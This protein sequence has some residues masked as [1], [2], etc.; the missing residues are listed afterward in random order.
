MMEFMLNSIPCWPIIDNDVM[1]LFH[2]VYV[3]HLDINMSTT[4]RLL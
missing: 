2:D 1:S 3:G 4:R